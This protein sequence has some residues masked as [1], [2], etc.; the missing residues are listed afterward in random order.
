MELRITHTH[1]HVVAYHSLF[2]GTSDSL[3]TLLLTSHNA[4]VVDFLQIDGAADG[5]HGKATGARVVWNRW[6]RHLSVK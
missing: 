3:V 1:T 4:A 6:Y 2:V 5:H